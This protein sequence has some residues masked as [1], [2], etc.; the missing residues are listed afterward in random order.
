VKR[1]PV[2]MRRDCGVDDAD[3]GG[4]LMMM[5]VLVIQRQR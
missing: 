3:I 2:A 4:M 5:V 1:D